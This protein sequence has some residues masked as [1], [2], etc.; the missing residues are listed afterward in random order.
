MPGASRVS[1]VV[2]LCGWKGVACFLDCDEKTAR[3]WLADGLPVYRQSTAK[4]SRVFAFDDELTL[5][6][7]SRVV[8]LDRCRPVPAAVPRRV[9]AATSAA[10]PRSRGA[11]HPDPAY[12]AGVFP[13]PAIE[14][15]AGGRSAQPVPSSVIGVLPTGYI[16]GGPGFETTDFLGCNALR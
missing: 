4:R 12:G 11:R 3:R 10:T 6:R 9:P 1:C 8:K 14:A 15:S 2:K 16:E 13:D 7:N 5:W